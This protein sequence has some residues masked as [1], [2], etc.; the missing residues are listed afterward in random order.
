MIGLAFPMT[1]PL[2]A[3]PHESASGETMTVMGSAGVPTPPPGSVFSL[4]PDDLTLQ[5]PVTLPDLFRLVPGASLQTNSRGETLVFLRGAGERQTAVFLDG[6][7]LMIPWDNRL[8]LTGIPSTFLGNATVFSG[9]TPARF[10]AN[11]AGGVIRLD[12]VAPMAGL[13]ARGEGGS[14]GAV[15][16]EASLSHR[17]ADT[18]LLVTGGFLARDGLS[19]PRGADLPFS[20]AEARTRTNTDLRQ[21]NIFGRLAY[22]PDRFRLAASLFHVTS[23]R[24]IAPEGDRDPALGDVRFWRYPDTNLTMGLL[25]LH[26]PTGGSGLFQTFVGA[27]AFGQVID[28]FTSSTYEVI[29]DRQIDQDRSWSLRSLY[30]DHLGPTELVFSFNGLLSSHRQTDIAFVDGVAPPDLPSADLFRQR[31][32]SLGLDTETTL[33]DQVTVVL[34]LGVDRFEAPATGG[35]P[36]TDPFTQ[37]HATGALIWSPSPSWTFRAAAGRQSR[38]PTLRE[39]FGTALDRF[40]INPDLKAERILLGEIGMQWHGA[41]AQMQITPFTRFV[42]NAID[43]QVVLVDGEPL[44]QRINVDGARIFGI[45]IAGQAALSEHWSLAGHVTALRGRNRDGPGD[46]PSRLSER[47]DLI[48]SLTLD[49]D[50]GW[51]VTARAEIDHRGRAFSPDSD[52]LLVPLPRSTAF[53]LR[54][55]Y[56]LSTAFPALPQTELYLRVDNLTNATVVPQLGLPEPGRLVRGGLR[57]AL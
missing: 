57:F 17:E 6:V 13:T 41:R 42:N 36:P 3:L 49:Y 33:G 35:R 12:P 28:S 47:P 27:Q 14:R 29:E 23:E 9:P 2:A 50:T 25:S 8:D 52:G 16:G 39:L 37:P 1:T 19:L 7:P 5:D 21:A 30:A 46:D 44:R 56:D 22:E 40:L 48:A 10:G 20:Q 51:G 38:L 26:V 45:E 43:Q 34:G 32:I 4:D 54:L 15:L 24:G 18:A 11:T 31:T 53:N 55:S